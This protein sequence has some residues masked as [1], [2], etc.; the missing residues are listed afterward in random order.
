MINRTLNRETP[1]W[2]VCQLTMVERT[3]A[4]RTRVRIIVWSACPGIGQRSGGS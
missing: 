4:M 3:F 2:Y 1:A